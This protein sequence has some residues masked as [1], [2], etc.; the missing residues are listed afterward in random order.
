MDVKETLTR[1]SRAYKE[2]SL[3][4]VPAKKNDEYYTVTII[5]RFN[6]FDVYEEKIKERATFL[7][8]YKETT[9]KNL[10]QYYGGIGYGLNESDYYIAFDENGNIA[11]STAWK[12]YFSA[13]KLS[14]KEEK[15]F[16]TIET[17]NVDDSL[18]ML[19]SPAQN[20]RVI[21]NISSLK[22]AEDIFNAGDTGYGTN[23]YGTYFGKNYNYYSQTI[24]FIL[25]SGEIYAWIDTLPATA[26]DT[27]R[28]YE[29]KEVGKYNYDT[30]KY[31]FNDKDFY[32]KYI[33][34]GFKYSLADYQK[35]SSGIVNNYT[36]Y[37]GDCE[38][39]S[40]LRLKKGK[41]KIL[42]ALSCRGC[43]V[44]QSQEIT[45]DKNMILY[46]DVV[47]DGVIL[48]TN[49]KYS[50][51]P[52][53]LLYNHPDSS[54]RDKWEISYGTYGSF[55]TETNT[56]RLSDYKH[57][58]KQTLAEWSGDGSNIPATD[59]E[60]TNYYTGNSIM[61]TYKSPTWKPT[62]ITSVMTDNIAYKRFLT[63]EELSKLTNY[64]SHGVQM[65]SSLKGVSFQDT[66]IV[67][68]FYLNA[69]QNEDYTYT[70]PTWEEIEGAIESLSIIEW[71]TPIEID[72]DGRKIYPKKE[73]KKGQSIWSI[74]PAQLRELSGYNMEI[75]DFLSDKVYAFTDS[76][77]NRVLEYQKSDDAD[78]DKI[79]AY[80]N[81]QICYFSTAK[82][83]FYKNYL[84]IVSAEINVLDSWTE[85]KH[86]E[87][88]DLVAQKLY[89]E[90][91]K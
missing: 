55:V 5:P 41:Y 89:E 1:W 63:N 52:Y 15:D 25:S 88:F 85:K 9:T 59:C 57:L 39:H 34:V 69:S 61:F 19:N 48:R 73:I 68:T 80:G 10:Q 87:A 79:R 30:N 32:Q 16:Y 84:T 40:F 4:Y 91:L 56:Y 23:D 47:L 46:C 35:Y 43:P 65:S 21:K 49:V 27:S 42:Q 28:T 51:I 13:A 3:F 86:E 20:M 90:Q 64:T 38:Y 7:E 54:W 14:Y 6:Y 81:R 36:K 74:E 78:I 75:G 62:E 72:S 70:P 29:R 66:A 37:P 45:V 22:E 58:I 26:V 31:I 50:S 33:M 83:S 53:H 17:Y 71:F 8:V 67:P 76:I 44:I 11:D 12:D 18:K 60:Y 82:E 77:A 24:L 2:P